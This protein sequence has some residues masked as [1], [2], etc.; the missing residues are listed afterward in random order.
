MADDRIEDVEVEIDVSVP[1]PEPVTGGDE[2]VVVVQDDG[3]STVDVEQS[4]RIALLEERLAAAVG[5]IEATAVVAT[6]ASAAAS[7]AQVSAD[8]ASG[9]AAAA[10]AETDAVID[11]VT[12]ATEPAPE[13][14]TP[15]KSKGHWFF[16]SKDELIGRK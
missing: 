1:D 15:P 7:D 14:D 10:A 6:S 12:A 13:P 11:A 2:T 9:Q 16:R 5:A 3:P 4:S 8:A